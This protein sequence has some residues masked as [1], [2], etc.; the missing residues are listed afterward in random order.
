MS[1][2]PPE[3][4]A[5]YSLDRAY[6]SRL[7]SGPLY[8]R[9]VNAD[10]ERTEADG[11]VTMVWL[12]E[13]DPESPGSHYTA[14]PVPA[15][16]GKGT[17][18]RVVLNA[19][20]TANPGPY[21]AR[22]AYTVDGVSRITEQGIEIGPN[23]PTYDSLPAGVRDVVDQVW[24]KMADLFDSPLGGPHL[25]VYVQTHFGRERIAQLLRSAVGRMNTISQP[26]QTLTVEKF[27]VAKWGG[28]LVAALWVEVIKHLHRSYLEQPDV[29]GTQVARLDRSRYSSQWAEVLRLEQG[30]LDRMLDNFKMANMMLGT[31][32]VLVSGGAYPRVSATIA[33]IRGTAAARGLWIGR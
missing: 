20:H 14:T 2:T 16:D 1:M 28:L 31:G 18:Y 6:F 30:E 9:I 27:P 25:Q 29:V 15:V 7:T 33:P 19:E 5:V 3:A 13:A 12:N 24:L 22:W 32:R 10:G 26:H 23:S 17:D 21:T 8:L 11:P 4:M